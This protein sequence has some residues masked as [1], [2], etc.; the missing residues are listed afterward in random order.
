M[1]VFSE[2]WCTENESG[3]KNCLSRKDFEKCYFDHIQKLIRSEP[4]GLETS[5]RD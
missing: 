5:L 3:L 4:D 1:S 2:F